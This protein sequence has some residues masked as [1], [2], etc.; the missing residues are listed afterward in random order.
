MNFPEEM[1]KKEMGHQEKFEERE[2]KRNSSLT[3]AKSEWK[4]TTQLCTLVN[5]RECKKWP[6]R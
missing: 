6:L 2:E 3:C 1:G 4:T 5:G